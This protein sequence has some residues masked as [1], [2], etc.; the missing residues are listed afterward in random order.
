MTQDEFR[1]C[2]V[3]YCQAEI[4]AEAFFEAALRK[5]DEPTYRYKISSLLQLE[6]ETKARLRPAILKHSA[7]PVSRACRLDAAA[8]RGNPEIYRVRIGSRRSELH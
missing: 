7:R 6:T 1:E 4:L 2:L 3:D 8:W 5:F